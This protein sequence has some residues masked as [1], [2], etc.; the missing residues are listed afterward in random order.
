MET[1]LTPREENLLKTLRQTDRSQGE[2]RKIAT[3]ARREGRDDF[4]AEVLEIL[5]QRF[6]EWNDPAHSSPDHPNATTA[7]F[8]GRTR[9][10][11]SAKDA[12]I[13]LFESMIDHIPG[14]QSS[15]LN[16][17]V[18]LR[19]VVSGARGAMYLAS[20]PDSLFPHDPERASDPGNHHRLK[21]GWYLNLNLNNKKK[22]ER[23]F[24]LAQFA[25]LEY[26]K[27]WSWTGVPVPDQS[28]EE[29]FSGISNR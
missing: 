5:D 29:I 19:M 13:W 22:D 25:S 15:L 3:D 18:F 11:D 2:L 6:P 24:A 4:E 17:Y 27:D 8:R 16:D 7:T 1:D 21:N 20:N 26:E 28:L 14:Q 23:L 9:H 10:F 12:Y